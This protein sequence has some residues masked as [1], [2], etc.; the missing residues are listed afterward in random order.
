M[1]ILKF[2]ARDRVLFLA[3]HPDDESLAGGGLLQRAAAAGAK[4]RVIFATDGDNNPWPQ[5]FLERRLK[6]RHTDRARWG[7]RRRK[8]AISAL[9]RLGLGKSCA[10][11]LSMPDQG[12]TR[13]LL[14]ADENTLFALYAELTEWQ[15]TLLVLPSG[16][17]SHPDHSALFV[18]M[19]LALARAEMA[20][21]QLRY[22]VHVPKRHGER[23]RV[24][25]R[26]SEEEI[27]AKRAAILSHESQM[28]LSQKRFV[29]YADETEIFYAA[30]AT[31]MPHPAISGRL[32]RGALRLTL[33]LRGARASFAGRTLLLAMESLTEGSARWT[34]ALPATSRCVQLTDARTGDPVRLATV[35]IEGRHAEVS[36]PV[37]P[38]QPLRQI[39]AKLQGRSFLFDQ[40]GWQEL[41]ASAADEAALARKTEALIL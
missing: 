13:L 4:A 11:F 38:L 35:R 10:R 1:S 8:E 15:P 31:V 24:M 5:R 12:A 32:E 3:P 14:R 25:L 26:L 23:G 28:A 27:A 19:Q 40:S 7:R 18:L 33:R 21:R 37:A 17:D 22:L 30:P 2:T 20:P 36:I 9:A 29:A 34:L 41:P 6:I 39:F 16:A